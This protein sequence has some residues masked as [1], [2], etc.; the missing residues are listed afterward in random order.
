MHAP[1]DDYQ[2]WLAELT[3]R[4]VEDLRR[5]QEL[6]ARVVEA[7]G[8]GDDRLRDALY[9]AAQEASARYLQDASRLGLQYYASLSDLG[10]RYAERVYDEVVGTPASG[11][12]RRHQAPPAEPIT[13][14][15][16]GPLGGAARGRFTIENKRDAPVDVSFFV[17]DFQDA[18]GGA[19][20]NVPVTFEPPHLP[21][22]PRGEAAVAIEIPLDPGL[23]DPHHRYVASLLVRGHDD[24]AMRLVVDVD[25][26]EAAA[27]ATKAEPGKPRARKQRKRRGT[28]RRPAQS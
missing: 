4:S 6:V 24:L 18:A 12:P 23:F 8:Q 25:A 16:G 3:R 19:P 10:R 13:C 28:R 22:D 7:A 9:R 17:S 20:F 15:L 5:Y 14:A 11:E 27:A 1:P 2:A 26:A 21:I